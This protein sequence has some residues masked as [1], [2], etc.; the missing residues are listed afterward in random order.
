MQ[1]KIT[2]KLMRNHD[3]KLFLKNFWDFEVSVLMF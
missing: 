2:L 1:V 3:F